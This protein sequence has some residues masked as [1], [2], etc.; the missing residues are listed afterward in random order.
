MQ[1]LGRFASR[2]CKGASCRHCKE[3]SDE[4]IHLLSWHGH[5]DPLARNDEKAGL[6]LTITH[7]ARKTLLIAGGKAGA[8]AVQIRA[9]NR[10]QTGYDRCISL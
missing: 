3:Q 1:Q 8:F 7:F 4:A 10:E 2:E 6:R 9:N 5:A